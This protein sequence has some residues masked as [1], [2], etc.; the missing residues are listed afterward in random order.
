MAAGFVRFAITWKADVFS[1]APQASSAAEF[2]T[3][4][5]TFR[6]QGDERGGVASSAR[7]AHLHDVIRWEES[8]HSLGCTGCRATLPEEG[9]G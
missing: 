3:M 9:C 5:I 8:P 2:G 6:A 4:G 1:G 7:E